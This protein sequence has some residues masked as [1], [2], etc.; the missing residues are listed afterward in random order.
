[1]LDTQ[2]HADCGPSQYPGK[3]GKGHWLPGYCPNPGGQAATPYRRLK[4]LAQE[5][6]EEAFETVLSIMRDVKV[7]ANVRL[8]AAGMIWD[9]GHGKP[10]EKHSITTEDGPLAIVGMTLAQAVALK[11]E[12][13]A[14]LEQELARLPEQIQ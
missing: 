7:A 2:D 14:L 1:M 13:D 8:V 4:A 11:R 12:T 6:S 9:R 5:H 10:K 3:D